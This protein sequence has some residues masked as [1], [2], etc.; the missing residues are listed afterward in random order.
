MKKKQEDSIGKLLKIDFTLMI[1]IL[2][3]VG[4]FTHL[5]PLPQNEPLEWHE[6][7]HNIE[8]TT[9][10][11]PKVPGN[12]HFMVVANSRK[13]GVNIKSIELFLNIKTTQMSLRFKYLFTI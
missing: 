9:T 4:V 11:S 5:N 2:G 12:N 1:I 6:R 3:I 13:E 10:I 7:E 8:F